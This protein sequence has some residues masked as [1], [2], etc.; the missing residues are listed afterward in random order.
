MTSLLAVCGAVQAFAAEDIK[1]DE[2]TKTIEIVGEITVRTP[3]AF[4]R[5]LTNAPWAENV[6][7]NSPGG[8]VQSAL[9][10]AE[11][12]KER[13]LSTIVPT[14]SGCASACAFIFLAGESREVR[15]ALGV[16][17]IFGLNNDSATQ[18]EL[19]DVIEALNSYGVDPALIPI[20]L[21]T[22]PGGMHYFTAE[23]IARY[24]IERGVHQSQRAVLYEENADGKTPVGIEGTVIW[25]VQ[26]REGLGGATPH[27]VATINFPGRE[28]IAEMTVSKNLDRSMPATHI[29]EFLKP[30]DSPVLSVNRLASKADEQDKGNI[31]IGVPATITPT[32]FMFALNDFPEAVAIN[33]D[34]LKRRDWIDVALSYQSGRR[35]VLA[36][37]KSGEGAKALKAVFGE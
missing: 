7:L 18:T 6:S 17:Q 16:H 21:R 35:A 15:G 25:S 23:E 10:I 1:S 3:L 32:L 11:E 30:A 26:N 22:A 8:V 20:M 24:G 37:N 36:I 13:R 4:R 27:A 33:S 12:V 31:F 9:L 14:G 28:I 29:F 5:A 2:A 34:L 19:S